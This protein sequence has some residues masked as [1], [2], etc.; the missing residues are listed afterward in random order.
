MT[1]APS[2]ANRLA[3]AA[4]IPRDAPVTI[5]TLPDSLPIAHLVRRVGRPPRMPRGGVS[6][7]S[8][9]RAFFFRPPG[10]PSSFTPARIPLPDVRH[11]PAP[12]T[13]RRR[14]R[15]VHP[16]RVRGR[17]P[18]RSTDR[19][20]EAEDP[21]DEVQRRGRTRPRRVL[22]LLVHLGHRPQG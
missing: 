16:R 2:A 6:V 17:Q 15:G 11:V 7:V 14:C 22:P 3:I 1:L 9:A 8:A 13:S 18:A 19:R 5:A 21:R 10:L 12:R 4:P 20:R